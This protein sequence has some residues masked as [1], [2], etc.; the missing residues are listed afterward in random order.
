MAKFQPLPPRQQKFFEGEGDLIARQW[1]QWFL[2]VQNFLSLLGGLPAP[3]TSASAGTP[4]Q[5]AFD[6]TFLYI[7]I[8]TNSWK[9]I[10]LT[11]F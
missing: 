4:G 5:Y 10:A 3:A 1:Y 9:R 11:A 6:N 8:S 2:L 7:C